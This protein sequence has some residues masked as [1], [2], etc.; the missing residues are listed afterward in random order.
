M[1]TGLNYPYP[2]VSY[3]T[4]VTH[5]CVPK[6]LKERIATPFIAGSSPVTPS[7]MSKSKNRPRREAKKPKHVEP[8]RHRDLRPT[9]IT[10]TYFTFEGLTWR[11]TCIESN[12]STKRRQSWLVRWASRDYPQGYREEFYVAVTGETQPRNREARSGGG[13]VHLP[14]NWEIVTVI[15]S[16]GV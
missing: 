13:F 10:W 14:K 4:T 15:P 3:T 7:T 2:G 16:K 6:R 12:P 9:E 8:V 11:E 5:G 1:S